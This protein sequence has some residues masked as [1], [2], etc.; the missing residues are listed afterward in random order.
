[1]ASAHADGELWDERQG[2]ACRFLHLQEVRPPG[3]AFRELTK[4]Q[5]AK[6]QVDR[7]QVLELV[8]QL[9]F[10]RVL[11]HNCARRAVAPGGQW[12]PRRDGRPSY[13]LFRPPLVERVDDQ[14]TPGF[15]AAA[16]NCPALLT[17]RMLR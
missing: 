3:V 4:E 15:P 17:I 9:G 6:A 1:M 5:L 16:R 13:R 8:Q 11:I 14:W 7:E 12:R 10:G 2:V